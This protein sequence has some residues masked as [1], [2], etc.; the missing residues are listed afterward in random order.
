MYETSVYAWAEPNTFD[1]IAQPALELRNADGQ[2]VHGAMY[3]KENEPSA[4]L[5]GKHHYSIF[6]VL[7]IACFLVMYS[8]M[9]LIWE[10]FE[11]DV[12]KYCIVIRR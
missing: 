8:C 11:V 4:T 2:E 5:I 3:V 7:I 6:I 10:I 1:W 9:Q 12:P